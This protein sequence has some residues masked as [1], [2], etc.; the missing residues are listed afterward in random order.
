MKEN[1]VFRVFP[2][3]SRRC[4]PAPRRYERFFFEKINILGNNVTKETVIRNNLEIDEGDPYN[5]IL[6]NK[7]VNV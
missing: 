7:S 2:F 5:E 1:N 3:P 4:N 6:S